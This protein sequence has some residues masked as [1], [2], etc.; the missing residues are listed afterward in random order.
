MMMMMMT[1]HV[2]S[3][4]FA[5]IFLLAS[6]A[7][8]QGVSPPPPPPPSSPSLRSSSSSS[9]TRLRH[10]KEAGCLHGGHVVSPGARFKPDPCTSC[11]CP[12]R[13]GQAVCSVQDCR[14]DVHCLRHVNVTSPPPP[15]RGRVEGGRRRRRERGGRTRSSSSSCCPR[16]A[17]QGCRHTD[18]HVYRRGEVIS[19]DGCSHCYCP[20]EGGA[21][22]CDVKP[23]PPVLCVDFVLAPPG[24]GSCC[25]RCPRGQNCQLGLRIIPRGRIV[26]SGGSLCHCRMKRRGRN[27]KL[28]AV[29]FDPKSPKIARLLKRMSS[30]TKKPKTKID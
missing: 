30:K 8:T 11:R 17:E 21:T 13:G 27:H 29:C 5:C 3:V 19:S 22:A 18:G 6:A 12:R 20:L 26:A 25:P 9:P 14:E 10:N 2:L 4:T 1:T 23:C 28:E 16:C 24:G 15:R 7:L